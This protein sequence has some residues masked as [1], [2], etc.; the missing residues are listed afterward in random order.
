MLLTLASLAFLSSRP[1]DCSP[2]GVPSAPPATANDN[3][4]PAGTLHDGVLTVR[5]VAQ[6]ATWYPEGE[7]GCGVTLY[8]FAE[9]GKPAQIPGPL[10]RVVTGTELRVTVH[11]TLD[12]PIGVWGLRD[13]PRSV[14]DTLA[15][16]IVPA[17][18]SHTFA[19]RATVPGTYFY[20]TNPAGSPAR[21]PTAQV[22]GQMLGGFIVDT[23]DEAGSADRERILIMTRWRGNPGPAGNLARAQSW[24]LTAFNGRSWPH[25]ERLSATVGDTLRW[26]VIAANNDGH[27]MH[28]HGFYFLVE[29][30]AIRGVDS[31]YPP[32]GRRLMVTETMGPGT[33]IRMRWVPE[34]AGNWIFH[35]HVMK[36]MS[37]YQ[38][39]DRMPRA[40]GMPASADPAHASHAMHEMAGLVMGITVQ[41]RDSGGRTVVR[42]ARTLHLFANQRD[43]VFGDHPGYGFVLQE[44]DRPPALDSVR[45]PGSLLILRRGERTRI[46]VHNRL[47]A[48][49]SVHWHGI[50]LDSYSDGV[51]GWSGATGSIAPPIAPGDTFVALM[52]PPRAGTFIYHVHNEAAEELPSG[53]YGALVVLEP[54][55][56][57]D[58]DRVFVIAEPGPSGHDLAGKP[59][60][61]NGTVTPP[62][63]VLVVGRT[64]P[65]RIVVISANT[66]YWVRLERD[67]VAFPWRAVA[68]DGADL[69]PAQAGETKEVGMGPGSTSDFEVT[70]TAPGT[71][72]LLV[73]PGAAGQ[74]L[75]R[76]TVVT[77]HVR[78]P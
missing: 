47:H 60:F 2:F 3:R 42:D 29:S 30:K 24:E 64:Y 54:G 14:R 16:V 6:L 33:T 20:W 41:A 50:E 39:L 75:G 35:C 73:D 45:I 44:G 53:L 55:A 58:A 38:R 9:E 34:R 57:P 74:R 70:P 71:L 65:F 5:L 56:A 32:A 22:F 11:N 61:V 67:S 51:S 27:Q 19:F 15:G 18:S 23:P 31:I 4:V 28:L 63:Q 49:L 25:T 77:F 68:R 1:P 59:P 8:A 48:P 13:P 10:L 52:T 66:F 46:V 72:R 37:A 76:P 17:D 26:R 36:H 69:P 43:R 7:Q 40:E 62:E 12:V 21:V 78:A